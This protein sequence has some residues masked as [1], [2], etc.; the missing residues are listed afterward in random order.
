MLRIA[1]RLHDIGRI[2]VPSAVLQKPTSLAEDE[3]TLVREHPAIGAAA[4]SKVPGL[5]T[6]AP[7]IRAHHEH[8]DGSGYPDGLT[9]QEIPLGAR[10]LAVADA[11]VA[12]TNDRPYRKARLL[13]EA[14]E[15]LRGCSG[16]QFDPEV[17]VAME[18]V[19]EAATPAVDDV[20]A[21]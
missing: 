21:A 11:Y 5:R 17:V 2:V 6:I 18:H 10:I 16:I 20:G 12:M 13:T 3:W 15:E 7:V 8:W 19:L 9:A 1:G 4:V 14:L